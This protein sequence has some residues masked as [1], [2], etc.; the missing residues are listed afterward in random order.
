MKRFLVVFLLAAAIVCAKKTKHQTK[1]HLSPLD[2]Y[3]QEAHRRAAEAQPL[4]PGSLYTPDAVFADLAA[5]VRARRVDDLVTVVV[6]EQASAIS[7]GQTKTSRDSGANASINSLLK[8]LPATSKLANLVSLNS[9]RSLDGEGTTSRQT[10]LTATLT[11]RVADV[12]PN[13]DLVIEG[14][15][16]VLVNSEKQTISLRGVVRQA[17]LS[18]ANTVLSDNVADM[19]LT[20]NGRGVVHDAIHRPN[21]L[22]R[23]L[24]GLLPF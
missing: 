22:Y 7:T 5:D 12:L 15:K 10:T 24:L 17:D 20:I 21:F 19:E 23:L 3:I 18:N 6:D 1:S 11:A 8:P 2:Q 16:T 4:S 13:G 9:S 14:T